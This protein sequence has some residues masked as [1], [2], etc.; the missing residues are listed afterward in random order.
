V[1]FTSV[2]TKIGAELASAA[3]FQPVS[4][5]GVNHRDQVPTNM[6]RLSRTP[7]RRGTRCQTRWKVPATV[8]SHSQQLWL[9]R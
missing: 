2:G 7:A 6:S 4:P 5:P 9:S 1:T 3:G 8:K